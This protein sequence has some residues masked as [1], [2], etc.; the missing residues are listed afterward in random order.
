[1]R[2]S[3]EHWH[4]DLGETPIENMF[5][6]TYMLT[7]P[8]DYV[9]LY[10]YGYKQAFDKR[11][12]EP[13]E[14]VAKALQI[15]TDEIEQ[16]WNYWEQM[17]LVRRKD[18]QIVFLSLRQLYLGIEP[19]EVDYFAQPEQMIEDKEDENIKMMLEQVESILSVPLRPNQV[20]TLL[21]QLKDYPVGL[22]VIIMSFVYSFETLQT[23]DFDYAL[24]V[25]RKWYIAGVRTGEDLEKHLQKE[26]DKQQEKE[27]RTTKKQ[28]PTSFTTAGQG[29]DRMSEEEMNALIQDKLKRQK[30]SRP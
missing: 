17:G 18:R 20:T 6:N 10:L 1:M 24:G 27:K 26:Q 30:R 3:L 15:S 14:E 4:V 25:W 29:Q 22:D 2:F 7:A 8:G 12:P 19:E 9:K 21:E 28:K 16:A 5:L 11:E 23:K 13:I